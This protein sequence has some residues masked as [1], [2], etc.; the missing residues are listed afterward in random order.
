MKQMKKKNVLT[1]LRIPKRKLPEGLVQA[2]GLLKGKRRQ[3]EAHLRTIRR[4]W[5]RREE[6]EWRLGLATKRN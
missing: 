2:V 3:M 4:E 6:K 5:A 1:E